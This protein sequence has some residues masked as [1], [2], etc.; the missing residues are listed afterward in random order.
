MV[1]VTVPSLPKFKNQLNDRHSEKADDEY[2]VLLLIRA[3]LHII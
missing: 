1:I 3:E 2:I